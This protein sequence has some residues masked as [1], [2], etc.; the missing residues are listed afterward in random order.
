MLDIKL[1][2]ENP[3]DVIARLA[4]KGKEAREEVMRILELDEA[5]RSVIA[6][7]EAIKAEQNKQTKLV[8][9]M[10]KEGKDVY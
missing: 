8:P 7:T 2:K 10:K 9:Q 4:A 3:E 5:R 1:I 6:E